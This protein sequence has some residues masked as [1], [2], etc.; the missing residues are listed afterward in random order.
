MATASREAGQCN[1]AYRPT[2]NVRGVSSRATHTVTPRM[3]FSGLAQY[4][5]RNHTVSTNLRLRWEYDPGNELFVVYTDENDT[6]AP[7]FP[8]VENRAFAVKI[9]R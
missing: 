1:I 5:S 3:F 4:N 2:T 6:N 7:G 9:D 8:R